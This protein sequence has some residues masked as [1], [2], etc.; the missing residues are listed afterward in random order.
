M[1]ELAKLRSRQVV[2]PTWVFLQ[3]LHEPSITKALAKVNKAAEFFEEN[4]PTNKGIT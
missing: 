4:L 2:F 3:E 1:D